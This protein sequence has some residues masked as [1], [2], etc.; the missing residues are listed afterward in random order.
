MA[1]NDST[2][3][4][5]IQIEVDRQDESWGPQDY[6]PDDRWIEI[7]QDEFNDLRWIVRTL[8]VEKDTHDINHELIQTIATLIRWYRARNS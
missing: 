8:V 3:L 7:V 1:S 5:D 6:V 4:H 2:I